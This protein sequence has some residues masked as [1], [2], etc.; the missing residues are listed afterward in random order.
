VIQWNKYIC[1]PQ[2]KANGSIRKYHNAKDILICVKCGYKIRSKAEG[3][4]IDLLP[5]DPPSLN[6]CYSDKIRN[7]YFHQYSINF[8][9]AEPKTGWGGLSNFKGYNIFLL[10][11]REIIEKSIMAISGKKLLI[12]LSGGN[13]F[14]SF[15]FAKYF[16]LVFHCDISAS[17]IKQAYKES[18]I[19]GISNIYFIRCDFRTLPFRFQIASCILLIDSLEYYGIDDDIN[20][21]SSVLPLLSQEASFIFDIHPKRWFQ[22]S[23]IFH[24]SCHHRSH[25][26]NMISKDYHIIT[27]AIGHWPI[28]FTP[29]NF[30]WQISN[31]CFLLPPLRVLYIICKDSGEEK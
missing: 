26:L 31:L 2:C 4:L 29:T 1:C 11:E 5:K 27:K 24:Y 7:Y 30:L 22:K 19:N 3:R 23:K 17:A 28:K 8:L 16:D 15:Y 6:F 13:G 25:L 12:D 18:V 10:K 21:I 14:Y 20:T 9:T